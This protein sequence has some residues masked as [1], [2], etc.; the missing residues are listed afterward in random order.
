MKNIITLILVFLPFIMGAQEYIQSDETTI[1]GRLVETKPYAFFSNGK[2]Y[3]MGFSY[4]KGEKYEAYMATVVS[5]EQS[6]QWEVPAGEQAVFKMAR[7][8]RITLKSIIGSTAES[9]APNDYMITS[10]YIIPVAKAHDMLDAIKEVFVYMKNDGTSD[11]VNIKVPYDAAS[12]LMLSYLE[13]L[14]ITG[15]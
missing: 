10:S 2:M 1:D 8:N 11:I 14:S 12:Y 7:G 5:T 4:M 15:R 6:S 3:L 9:E 13:L